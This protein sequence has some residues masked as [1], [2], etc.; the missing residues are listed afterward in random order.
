M[1]DKIL[2]VTDPDDSFEQGLRILVAYLEPD[3]SSLISDCLL[4]FQSMPNIIMY[5]ANE[6]SDNRWMIDKIQKSDLIIF[7]AD[8]SNQ[9]M[10]GYLAGK[11][12]SCYFGNLKDL[13]V[14]N[15]AVILDPHQLK[16]NLERRFEIYGKF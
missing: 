12:N 16:E 11:M 13:F 14:V 1:S 4:G 7:N 9:T 15:T 6:L 3:Q 2:L 10:V 5:S 8:S